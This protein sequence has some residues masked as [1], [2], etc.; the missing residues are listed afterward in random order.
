ML[1]FGVFPF[2]LLI[3]IVI[4]LKSFDTVAYNA[5]NVAALVGDVPIIGG[6][7]VI[8]KNDAPPVEV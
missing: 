8:V 2:T 5:S 6:F 3:S 7:G 4:S 1:E